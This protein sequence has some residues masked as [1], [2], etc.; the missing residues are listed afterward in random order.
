MMGESVFFLLVSMGLA[1]LIAFSFSDLC[2]EL[3]GYSP[4]ELFSTGKVW[5]V[6]GLVCIVLLIFTGVIPA[7]IYSRTPVSQAFRPAAHGRRIWKLVLLALQFLAT[8]TIVCLLVLVWRQYA[9]VGKLDMGL[10][11][12]NIAMFYRYPMSAEKTSTVMKELEKLPFVEGVASGDNDPA[13]VWNGNNMWTE[14]HEDDNVNICDQESVNPALFDVLGI[15][16]VDGSNFNLNADSTINEIIVEE[17]M[18]GV[19]QKYF[20]ETDNDIIGKTIYITGHM[21][22]D[23][24]VP[25]FT[26][27]GV[28]GNIRRGSFENGNSDSRAAVFFPTRN[29]RGNVFIRFTEL[30]PEN[31]S[32]AQKV[33]DSINDGEDIY[34]LPYKMR[35]EAKRSS[36][37]MFGMAVMVVGIAIMIIALIGLIGYVADEVNRRAKEIA[38]RKVNGTSANKI[39][40]LFCIDVLKVALPSLLAGGALAMVIGQRWL[41][42]FT[43]R[44]SLSPISMAGCLL[45]LLILIMGVVVVNTLRVARSN[46]IEHLRS[47]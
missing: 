38:I 35:I 24:P 25:V 6:E 8:G 34:I 12:E 28:V 4:K 22:E 16:F 37:K 43:D 15:K 23:Q 7:I 41:S 14:G 13:N 2:K 31:L 39:V 42:Q 44:V 1:I 32:A 45:V 18:V 3:L 11:Y 27:V 47:E 19:L 5:I 20:H 30:T 26:I 33:L 36:I 21:N 10:D 9:M 40:R 17:R 29:I 46:P